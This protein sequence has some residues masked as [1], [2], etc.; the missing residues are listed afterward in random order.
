MRTGECLNVIAAGIGRTLTG[1]G[2]RR[3]IAASSRKDGGNTD[4]T[5]LMGF[6]IT[7]FDDEVIAWMPLPLLPDY[8]I[9]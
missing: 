2:M 8:R 1:N 9:E 5:I 6:I 7:R 4:I 3:M